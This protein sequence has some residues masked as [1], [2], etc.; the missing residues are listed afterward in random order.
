MTLA[1]RIGRLE[2][3]TRGADDFMAVLIIPPGTPEAEA[4]RL[5]DAKEAEARRVGY[6]GG[7]VIVDLYH[8]LTS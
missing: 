3:T 8:D 5:R 7:I 4:Q 2:S 1:K 6:D